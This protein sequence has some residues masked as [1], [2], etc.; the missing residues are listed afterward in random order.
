MIGIVTKY[1]GSD[2]FL[3]SLTAEK[4]LRMELSMFGG[5]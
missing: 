1:I 3:P 5:G 2:W 4:Y